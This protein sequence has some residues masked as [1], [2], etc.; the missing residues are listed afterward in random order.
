METAALKTSCYKTVCG[1]HA[2]MIR[3]CSPL[4][5]PLQDHLGEYSSLSSWLSQLTAPLPPPPCYTSDTLVKSQRWLEQDNP[6]RSLQR[7]AGSANGF[8]GRE[9]QAVGLSQEPFGFHTSHLPELRSSPEGLEMGN[10]LNLHGISCPKISER[11][12][13]VGQ[14]CYSHCTVGEAESQRD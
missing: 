6:G 3:K 8:E 4:L 2:L 7:M 13:E 11:S 12:R 1:A 14:H 9:M 5:P 10:T